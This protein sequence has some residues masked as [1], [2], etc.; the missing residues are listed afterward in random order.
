M[1]EKIPDWARYPP[2][3]E[4]GVHSK[5]PQRNI[6]SLSQDQTDE[7]R[8]QLVESLVSVVV[9]STT[10]MYVPGGFGTG[11]DQLSDWANDLAA[12]FEEAAGV[13]WNLL[14][15]TPLI[16]AILEVLTGKEDGDVNDLGTWTNNLIGEIKTTIDKIV[17]SLFGWVGFGFTQEDAEQALLDQASTVAALSTAVTALEN[18]RNNQA[19][20]GKS[21]VVDFTTRATASSLGS[22]FSQDYSG[23]G[24]GTLELETG[25]GATWKAVSDA[26]RT[27]DFRYLDLETATDYQKVWIA[28]GSSPV[29]FFGNGRNEIHGR[30]NAAGTTYVYAAMQKTTAQLGCVVSGV[31]TVFVTKSSGFNFKSTGIYALECGT[32]GGLRV[33]RLLEGGTV[34]LT[35]TEVG[36]TSQVG[37]SYRFAGGQVFAEASGLGTTSP[38]RMWAYAV[39]D[40]QPPTVVGSGAV[41]YRVDTANVNI[42]AGTHL[43]PADFFDTPGANSLDI[44]IDFSNNRFT[45]SVAGWYRFSLRAKITGLTNTF[46]THLQLYLEKT[47]TSLVT[48]THFIG[49]DYGLYNGDYRPN[50]VAGG[51]EMYLDVGDYVEPGYDATNTEGA[52]EGEASGAETSF[53]ITRTGSLG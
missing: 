12:G 31:K 19:V 38:G 42:A 24:T 18:N 46:P 36:T 1:T 37:A 44:D 41:M 34:I 52:F 48:T 23:S 25:V 32:V 26:S 6:E 45:V 28:F 8:D 33:F 27:C 14:Q 22:D 20:G 3:A 9:Q 15:Q 53:I 17:T 51:T 49:H 29:S 13:V 50:G 10:G 16:G 30:K 35:H 5:L 11:S 43:F 7:M 4:G 21:A 47:D 2:P 39:G 40:N